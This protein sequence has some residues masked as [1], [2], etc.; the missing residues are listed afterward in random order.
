M[1]K[2]LGI[3]LQSWEL[4]STGESDLSVE[5][6]AYIITIYVPTVWKGTEYGLGEYSESFKI[7][8]QTCLIYSTSDYHRYASISFFGFGISIHKQWGY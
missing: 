2:K 7:Q 3:Y 1:T 8:A 4:F 5:S 6:P